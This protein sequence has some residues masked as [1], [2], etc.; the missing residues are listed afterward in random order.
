[1]LPPPLERPLSEEWMFLDRD[2]GRWWL[3]L[4]EDRALAAAACRD[5]TPN[6]QLLLIV[7][8][9]HRSTCHHEWLYPL[10]LKIV[11]GLRAEQHCG[12]RRRVQRRVEVNPPNRCTGWGCL[13]GARDGGCYAGDRIV[14]ANCR[15]MATVDIGGIVVAIAVGGSG[16]VF[17]DV[18]ARVLAKGGAGRGGCGG[19]GVPYFLQLSCVWCTF[20]TL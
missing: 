14:V 5:P 19:G 18:D 16:G 6:P 12:N 7:L 13:V 20:S 15:R 17:G 8:F 4:A 2:G 3:T 9:L 11:P 1:M 10:K